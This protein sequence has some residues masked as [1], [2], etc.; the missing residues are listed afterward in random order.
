MVV[1][2]TRSATRP[3]TFVLVTAFVLALIISLVNWV[4][5]AAADEF[6]LGSLLH[7]D[8]YYYL[9]IAENVVHGRGITFDGSKRSDGL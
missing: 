5:I 8:G 9:L 1:H 6:L 4:K 7:D 2:N 3:H